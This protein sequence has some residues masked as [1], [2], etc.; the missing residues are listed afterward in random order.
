MSWWKP[1][2]HSTLIKKYCIQKS[3]TQQV[4]CELHKERPSGEASSWRVYYQ[5]GLPR[6]VSVVSNK[7]YKETNTFMHFLLLIQ[8]PWKNDIWR[9]REI[10]CTIKCQFFSFTNH[11]YGRRYQEFPIK[12]GIELLSPI[13][14]KTTTKINGILFVGFY[15]KLLTIYLSIRVRC[16]FGVKIEN[17]VFWKTLT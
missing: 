12:G 1:K 4:F 3:N 8:F 2:L 9:M 5:W 7:T 14:Y 6:L 11:L 10:E 13:F 17:L 16:L 15:P